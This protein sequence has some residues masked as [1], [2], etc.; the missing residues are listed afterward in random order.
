MVFTRFQMS[1]N[2]SH[3]L[4]GGDLGGLKAALRHRRLASCP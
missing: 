1:Q 4:A 3:R 2:F